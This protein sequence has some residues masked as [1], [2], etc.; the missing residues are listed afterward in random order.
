MSVV[1]IKKQLKEKY[2][3][4]KSLYKTNSNI[5]LN[6]KES[7]VDAEY[8]ATLAKLDDEYSDYKKNIGNY[9]ILNADLGSDSLK[10]RQLDKQLGLIKTNFYKAVYYDPKNMVNLETEIE[11]DRVQ[12]YIEL[13][14]SDAI[15]NKDEGMD[16]SPA[17]VIL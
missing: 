10:H 12:Q 6:I 2:D 11:G 8:L 15:Y 3:M 7:N 13:L 14:E 4:V 9:I 16:L 5:M 1:D 17:C